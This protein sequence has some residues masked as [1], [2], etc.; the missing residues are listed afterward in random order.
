M[1][2]I[3]FHYF[4]GYGAGDQIR[5][6]LTV[7]KVP[8]EDVRYSREEWMAV[9]E[10]GK[11]EFKQVPVL[12]VDGHFYSQSVA[13]LRM[14]GKQHGYYTEDPAVNYRIDS[15][16]D[17]LND[18][19]Q[20]MGK[21]AFEQDEEK[22]KA[23]FHNFIEN[24]FPP[25]LTAIEKRIAANSSP[26]HAVGD[27]LTIADFAIGAWAYSA[28]YNEGNPVHHQFQEVVAKFPHVHAYLTHL[29]EHEFKEF[30]EHRP[31]PRPF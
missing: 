5:A 31:K 24:I 9:K 12:E 17:A 30:L 13:I 26:H 4:D 29:G 14:L 11:F 3:K 2:T 23:G 16:I 27:K 10:S 19:R 15:T 18:L 6:L 21:F 20:A 8:F 22:K 28:V 1:S 7:A 25:W